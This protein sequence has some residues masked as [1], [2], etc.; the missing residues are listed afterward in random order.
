MDKEKKAE[1]QEYEIAGHY[2]EMSRICS[3]ADFWSIIIQC[4]N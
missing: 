1:S 2:L 3:E 4:G